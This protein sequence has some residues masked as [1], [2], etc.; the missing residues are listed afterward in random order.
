[1]T[2]YPESPLPR[3]TEFSV[4]ANGSSI[5]VYN[6]GTFRCSPFAFSGIVTI[7]VTYHLGAIHSF[8]INPSSKGI[9]A[10]QSG[11][12]LTFTLDRPQ[13]LEVQI[14][15]ATAQVVDGNKLLYLFADAPEVSA[16]QPD[17]PTVFYFGPGMHHLPE[18]VLK[19][20]DSDPQT[21][22]YVAPGAVLDAAVAIHRTKPFRVYGRGFIQNPGTV[23]EKK[24]HQAHGAI[25]LYNCAGV[26]VED[27]TFF[28]SV[29][30]GISIT[31]GHG[32]RVRNVK[33]LHYIVNS[34]GI[35][36][37]GSSA[38]SVVE[39]CF[40]V[41]NDNLIVIGGTR[42]EGPSGNL[43]RHCTFIKSSYA[44]KVPSASSPRIRRF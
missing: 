2:V 34:D 42:G 23:A 24:A 16:P 44:G 10:R 11:D 25:N 18:G 12:T 40:I 38:G 13:K 35:S 36:L 21:A 4:T 31:G 14:N 1:V 37:M 27:V 15:D 22:L 17:D 7:A 9:V 29:E 41:G 39:D 20:E 3:A 32:N 43:V 33:A 5:A 8:Q 19:I 26:T 30:H 6:A 28:N